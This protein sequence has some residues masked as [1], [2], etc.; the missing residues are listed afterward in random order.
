M[1][2]EAKRCRH[3]AVA[4]PIVAVGGLVAVA[5]ASS[6][7]SRSSQ[8][9]RIT[10]PSSAWAAANRSIA[11]SA[12]ATSPSAPR[13]SS[14]ST[15]TPVAG[16][17]DPSCP[18][19][20]QIVYRCA[21][22]RYGTVAV[23]APGPLPRGVH[24]D[25]RKQEQVEPPAAGTCRGPAPAPPVRAHAPPG[26]PDAPAPHPAPTGHRPSAKSSLDRS[27][28]SSASSMSRSAASSAS[29]TPPGIAKP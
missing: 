27:V 1:P 18:A 17:Q 22:L 5:R 4:I 26:S 13:S 23:A 8:M 15:R 11:A 6:A 19:S 3:R 21:H 10:S 2:L 28:I 24:V 7:R 25:D 9:S 20:E 12:S 14:V 29:S 16:M